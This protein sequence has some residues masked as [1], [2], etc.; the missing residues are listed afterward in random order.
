MAALTT[1]ALTA[2]D[3]AIIP[4]QCE[5]FAIQAINSIFGYIRRVRCEHNH[6]LNYKLLITMFDLRGKLHSQLYE[7]IESHYTNA[8]FETV[9]GFDSKLR[10]SQIAG[11]PITVY[12]TQNP[13]SGTISEF[14][15]RDRCLCPR[16]NRIKTELTI[17]FPMG[18]HSIQNP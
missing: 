17:S 3:L 7:R 14:S 10:A 16:M 18:N 11:Q 1:A 9:I 5:Y 2:A 4:T 6:Q 8:M 12:C 13:R 15:E